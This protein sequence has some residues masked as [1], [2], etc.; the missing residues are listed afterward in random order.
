MHDADHLEEE[1]IMSWAE[2]A[3]K[4]YIS[5]ELA[6]QTDVTLKPFIEW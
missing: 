1:V 5:K 6:N 3:S 2:E 4:K